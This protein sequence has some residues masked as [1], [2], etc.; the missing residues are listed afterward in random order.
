ME[1]FQSFNLWDQEIDLSFTNHEPMIHDHESVIHELLTLNSNYDLYLV[2]I[3]QLLFL[4]KTCCISLR[5]AI[6][7]AEDCS[8]YFL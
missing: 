8:T 2:E 5:T 7:L 4:E 6:I 3:L 1:V